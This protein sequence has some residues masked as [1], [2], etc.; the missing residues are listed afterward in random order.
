MLGGCWWLSSCKRGECLVA[1]GGCAHVRE[2][3]V[4]WLL[5]VVLM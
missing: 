5:V 1:A 3:S 2:V 4:W